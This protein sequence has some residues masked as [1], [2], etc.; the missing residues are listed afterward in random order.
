MAKMIQS[1]IEVRIFTTGQLYIRENGINRLVPRGTDEH[2][3]LIK[4]PGLCR[5]QWIQVTK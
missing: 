5:S 4:T 2:R 3:K 1:K